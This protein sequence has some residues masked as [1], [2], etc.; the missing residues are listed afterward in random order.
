MSFPVILFT[1]LD[2]IHLLIRRSF[3]SNFEDLTKSALAEGT[4]ALCRSNEV[5]FEFAW[6]LLDELRARRPR[7][8][9]GCAQSGCRPRSADGFE[10]KTDST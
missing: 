4:G 10:T 6:N 9:P 8:F 5:L 7:S 3:P 2:G 1:P